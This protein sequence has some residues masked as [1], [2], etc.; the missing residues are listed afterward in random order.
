MYIWMGGELERKEETVYKI[1]Y[2]K[3]TQK[4]LFSIKEKKKKTQLNRKAAY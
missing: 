1:Y 3:N 4:L 2:I